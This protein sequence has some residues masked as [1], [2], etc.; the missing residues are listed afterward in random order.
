MNKER[1]SW[2]FAWLPRLS[3]FN[4]AFEGLIVNELNGVAIKDDTVVDIEIPGRIILKQFGFDA[5]GMGK[6]IWC[7]MVIV[8]VGVV[9]GYVALRVLV[10]ERR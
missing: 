1:I 7:L 8:S 3:P 6:D 4:Y 2:W 9:L 10:K 5:D